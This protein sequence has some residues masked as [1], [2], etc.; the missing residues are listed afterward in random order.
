[1]TPA[2]TIIAIL[3]PPLAAIFGGVVLRA[4]DP[5]PQLAIGLNA[6]LPGTGLAALGRPILESVIAVVFAQLSLI[7][8]GGSQNLWM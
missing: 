5:A 8:T 3:L 1:M 4:R 7:L 6:L 2:F